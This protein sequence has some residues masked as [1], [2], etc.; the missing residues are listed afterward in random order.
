MNMTGDK[1]MTYETLLYDVSENIATITLNRPDS[2]NSINTK[3][4][5]ELLKALKQTARDSEVRAVILTG[6]GKGFCSGADLMSINPDDEN[7]S[8]GDHLRTGLNQIALAIR[9][10]EKPVI[11]AI[12]GVAAGAGT[13]LA[14]ACDVRLASY[15]ASFVF[16]AFANIGLVPDTGVTYFLPKL[17]GTSKALELALTADAKNKVSAHYAHE[18]GIVNH[19]APDDELMDEARVFGRKFAKMASTAVGLTKRAIYRADVHNLA[20]S[21]EYEAQLQ[22]ATFKTGDFREGV[23]AFIEKRAPQFTGS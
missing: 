22:T 17:V 21:L 23:Q 18:L 15:K 3:M 12:N 1:L 9:S 7:F 6:S 2:Y 14:L 20:E 16:A 4:E 13:G 19:L 8:I 11:C 5:H 10:L